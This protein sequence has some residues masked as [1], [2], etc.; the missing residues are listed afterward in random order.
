M[1]W[2]DMLHKLFSE[3]ALLVNCS[4]DGGSEKREE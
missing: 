3:M 1:K 4:N 2:K